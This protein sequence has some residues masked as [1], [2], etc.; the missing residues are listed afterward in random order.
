M[1]VYIVSVS[2]KRAKKSSLSRTRLQR[3]EK[4]REKFIPLVDKKSKLIPLNPPLYVYD[5]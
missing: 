5:L 3:N 1:A 2:N 4:N